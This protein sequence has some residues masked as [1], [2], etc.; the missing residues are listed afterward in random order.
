M[1]EENYER[2]QELF[3]DGTEKQKAQFLIHPGFF[4]YFPFFFAFMCE[5]TLW[6]SFNKDFKSR[7]GIYLYD[8]IHQ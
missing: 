4:G 7:M 2:I 3:S 5:D 1:N 8:N 6:I